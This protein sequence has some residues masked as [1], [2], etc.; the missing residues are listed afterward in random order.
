[1]LREQ[2]LVDCGKVS[3]RSIVDTAICAKPGGALAGQLLCGDSILA[4]YLA[5]ARVELS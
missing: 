4:A 3:A 5:L 1:V 2:S